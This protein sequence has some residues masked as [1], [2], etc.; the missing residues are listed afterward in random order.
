V[1]EEYMKNVTRRKFIGAAAATAGA[2]FA[3]N[4]NTLGRLVPGNAHARL[5]GLDLTTFSKYQNTIFTFSK[6]G[7]DPV[8]LSLASVKDSR[9]TRTRA[10]RSGEECFVL[11]F[12]GKTRT[13]LPQDTYDVHHQILG[14][15]KLFITEGQVAGN[16]GT[17][18]AVIN[19]I[20]S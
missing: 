4:S 17:F 5:A 1:I 11:K 10:R 14:D 18:F 3:L 12:T 6:L 9:P 13:E 7:I 19:R 20:T 8:N 15:F 2:A 16:T